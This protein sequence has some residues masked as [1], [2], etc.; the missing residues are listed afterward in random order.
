MLSHCSLPSPPLSP[1][2]S[3]HT[4]SMSHFLPLAP[5]HPQDSSFVTL[6]LRFVS[7]ALRHSHASSPHLRAPSTLISPCFV[8]LG[9]VSIFFT[10]D[11]C[12]ARFV[13]GTLFL[14]L[15]LSRFPHTS[16]PLGLISRISCPLCHRARAPHA[17]RPG[18]RV[19]ILVLRVRFPH[20][21]SLPGPISHVS[22]PV[23]SHSRLFSPVFRH[24]RVLSP[25]L[26]ISTSS[27]NAEGLI[28]CCEC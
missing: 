28:G 11:A 16:S 25:W 10:H 23:L 20:L 21:S 7:L 15:V 4:P 13:P 18:A 27:L 17:L 3:H 19:L 8:S 1:S 6:V 24:R 26:H 9:P 14:I 2:N 22:S 12:L 5:A